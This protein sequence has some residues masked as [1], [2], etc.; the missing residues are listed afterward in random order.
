[1]KPRWCERFIC[2]NKRAPVQLKG[3]HNEAPSVIIKAFNR[4]G[5]IGTCRLNQWDW[6]AFMPCHQFYFSY[7][8]RDWKPAMIPSSSD[9][10][11]CTFIFS[12]NLCHFFAQ[13]KASAMSDLTEY[14]QA[15]GCLKCTARMNIL[16]PT[17]T[18]AHVL[19]CE[20]KKLQCAI[21]EV[22]PRWCAARMTQLSWSS[23]EGPSERT[24]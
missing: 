8:T 20:K 10:F 9:S 3:N 17:N 2:R 13:L 21:S 23:H 15:R 12:V 5:L 11:R 18:H 16:S 6:W 14:G 7:K 24:I 22:G 19:L 4:G 1:M